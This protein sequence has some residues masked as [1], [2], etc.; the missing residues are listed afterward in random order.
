[1]ESSNALNGKL[2]QHFKEFKKKPKNKT[3][4]KAFLRSFH[5]AYSE[6]K[7][8]PAFLPLSYWVLELFPDTK[9]DGMLQ[10]LTLIVQNVDVEREKDRVYLGSACMLLSGFAASSIDIR[11]KMIERGILE[12][13]FTS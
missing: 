4:R 3:R 7:K 9:Y 13:K 1:M 12:R 11:L 8:Y 6:F 5:A 10:M 2:I